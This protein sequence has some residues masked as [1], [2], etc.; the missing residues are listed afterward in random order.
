MSSSL[1]V[2][3]KLRLT[4]F[5]LLSRHPILVSMACNLYFKY[6]KQSFKYSSPSIDCNA[7]YTKS[8]KFNNLG[9]TRITP[10]QFII[11]FNQNIRGCIAS[12]LY[13]IIYK[14]V[15]IK[16]AWYQNIDSLQRALFAFKYMHI[17]WQIPFDIPVMHAE[18]ALI[19]L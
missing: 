11:S 9:I 8:I 18:V 15:T 2:I 12:N 4:F 16:I 7:E 6:V 13:F 3:H 19:L 10:L 17:I 14:H 5:G 1:A